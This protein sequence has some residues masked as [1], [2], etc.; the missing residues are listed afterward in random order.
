M[1]FVLSFVFG[2]LVLGASPAAAQDAT[3]GAGDCRTTTVEENI[4]LV[5]QLL[6][7][8]QTSDAAT[9]DALMADDY[10]HNLDRY[11]LPDDPA[12][13]ADEANLAV[14]IAQ[15]YPNV[16]Y[17]IDTI[18]GADDKVVVEYTQTYTE[19]TLTGETVVLETPIVVKTIA[20]FTIE[21]GEIAS[22]TA[23]AD[24]LALLTGLGVVTLP[25]IAP[26]ATPAS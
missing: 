21:C 24:E 20:I 6:E 4:A 9:I 19:H 22:L 14:M 7:A 12:S 15:F 25:E 2:L 3:P 26:E 11:G 10:T 13:N 1:F 17:T 8:I 18:F 5:E 16:T 23:V